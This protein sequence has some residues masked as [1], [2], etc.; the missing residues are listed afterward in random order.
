MWSRFN[1]T[2]IPFSDESVKRHVSL[3]YGS[4]S[5]QVLD[6][7]QYHQMIMALYQ[8]SDL[9]PQVSASALYALKQSASL[10]LDLFHHSAS[11]HQL[12]IHWVNLH[13]AFISCAMLIYCYT[14]SKIRSDITLDTS[15]IASKVE[16]CFE[17]LSLFRGVGP[18]V[19]DY[20]QI[21]QQLIKPLESQPDASQDLP[22]PVPAPAPAFDF[23]IES[24]LQGMRNAA[25]DRL[26]E[27]PFDQS[28]DAS[29]GM[30]LPDFWT[31]VGQNSWAGGTFEGGFPPTL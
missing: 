3:S 26:G 11:R 6:D 16:R 2:V 23:D 28:A 15:E 25:G 21:L 4:C 5:F 22:T 12:N 19:D 31:S 13:H 8:P 1:A 30:L 24:I 29:T 20:H 14:Q 17:V 18:I 27:T 10:S 9:V 7:V